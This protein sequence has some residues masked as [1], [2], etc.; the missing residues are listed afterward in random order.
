MDK[1]KGFDIDHKNKVVCLV[2][3]GRRDRHTKFRTE[4]G[5]LRKR[6]LARHHPGDQFHLKY[7]VNGVLDLRYN[8]LVDVVDRF[9][10]C[11]PTKMTCGLEKGMG[12]QNPQSTSHRPILSMERPR[13]LQEGVRSA[14]ARS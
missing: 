10:K 11:N 4:V 5:A 12:V 6:L 9:Q 8:G 7:D 1:S 3:A 13:R 2:Q 14:A